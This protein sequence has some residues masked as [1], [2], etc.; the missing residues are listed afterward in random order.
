MTMCVYT[1]NI[2]IWF[3]GSVTKVTVYKRDGERERIMGRRLQRR[4][5]LGYEFLI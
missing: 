5:P 1:D 4:S 3:W 2:I